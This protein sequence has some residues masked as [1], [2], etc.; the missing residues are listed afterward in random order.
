MKTLIELYDKRAVE[1]VLGPEIF[2]PETVIYL[3]PA[4]TGPDRFRQNQI[5]EYFAYRKIDAQIFFEE[6]SVYR[7]DKILQQLRRIADRYPDIAVDV[8]GGTDAALFAAGMFAAERNVP[9]FTYSRKKNCFYDISGASFADEKNCDIVYSVKDIFTMAGGTLR[10]GRVDNSILARYSDT[11]EEFFDIFMEN[12]RKW[13][14]FITYMQRISKADQSGN[15]S[16]KAEG[17]Y[18]QKG[19]NGGRVK[20]E[21]V[22]L[23]ALAR[24]GYISELVIEQDEYVSFRFADDNIRA[25][26]RDVGSV[27]E[28][29]MYKMC[30]DAQ[31]FDDVVSSAVVEWGG[32]G[33]KDSVCNEL[34]VVATRGIIPV[35]ISCK[36]CEVHTEALNELAILRDRFGGKTAKAVIATT[37]ICNSAVRHRAAQ[38]R[39]AVIDREEM[40][41]KIVK[42]R[43]KV[44]MKV[45]SRL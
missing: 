41:D 26:L 8:T 19:D 5:R 24:I 43:L 32:T 1:N 2:R 21:P 27:L 11:F 16:L 29:Y 28:L 40:T 30:R 25:W 12:R 20:A 34:D 13:P 33:R 35:F 45:R 22:I 7:A 39:I 6:C 18:V 4:D 23:K 37:E 44:I 9:A 31:I 17:D 42:E 10:Q 38:L 3:Y 36:A 15:Y 14:Q